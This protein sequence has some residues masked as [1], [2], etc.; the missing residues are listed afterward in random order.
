[1]TC[2]FPVNLLLRLKSCH[3]TSHLAVEAGGMPFYQSSCCWEWWHVVLPVILL[4]RLLPCRFTSH[5]AVAARYSVSNCI[6]QR[7][8]N[9]VCKD[10]RLFQSVPQISAFTVTLGTKVRNMLL[11]KA[12][13]KKT[14]KKRAKCTTRTTKMAW[15]KTVS[16]ISEEVHLGPAAL[17]WKGQ[18]CLGTP[19]SS[20]TMG[21]IN[22]GP[23]LAWLYSFLMVASGV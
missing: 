19:Q 23:A 4:L 14:A 11:V 5:R 17:L 22:R 6:R 8:L 10:T 16:T 20:Q 13:K 21:Q 3:F 9:R 15:V 1:M 2:R 12:E 18:G 7:S